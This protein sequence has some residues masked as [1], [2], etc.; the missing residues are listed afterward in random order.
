MGWHKRYAMTSVVARGAFTSRG[1]EP[2]GLNFMLRDSKKNYYKI[3][4]DEMNLFISL[5]IF[6][7]DFFAI[8]YFSMS[9]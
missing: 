1:A 9:I 8:F 7:T 6:L 3:Y 2:N 5:D 4:L